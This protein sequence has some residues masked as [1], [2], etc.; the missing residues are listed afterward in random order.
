MNNTLVFA[1]RNAREML[2]DKMTLIFGLGFPVVLLLLMQLIQA[3]IPVDLFSIGK[4][5]PGTALFGLSFISLFSAML[6]STDRGSA[7]MQR[8]LVSPLRAGGFILGYTL[9]LIIM[10]ACQILF[11]YLIA[12][13]F[14]LEFNGNLFL[15]ALTMLISSPLY[16][17]IGML[18]GSVLNDR[19]IGGI[20]G[21][22]LTN[23]SGWLSGTWFDLKDAGKTF[24][25]I[26]SLL[27]FVHSVD[28]GRYVL[29]G[30]Y[31]EAAAQ[32]I[33]VVI[34]A[35]A[36]FVLAVFVFKRKMQSDN[37]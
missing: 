36:L 27:P 22:L 37:F 4:L 24:G 35:A 32:L 14:G 6:I 21:A 5:I 16:I 18:C 3:N 15:S 10:S 19:Q 1:G 9:P 2:R 29:G 25:R 12:L 8:L 11:L 23:V 28:A 30:E 20:C 7:F 13:F 33:W 17:A 34:Y 31:K 26:A